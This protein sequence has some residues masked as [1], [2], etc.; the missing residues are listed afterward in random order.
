[1]GNR[2]ARKNGKYYDLK[3]SNKSFLQ[4]AKD[5]QTLGIKNWYFML[6]IYDYS[7]IEVDPF[8]VDKNGNT[9]L[10]KDQI[11]RI[12]LECARN[13]W[14]FLREISRIPDQG[15]TSIPY[16][17]NRGNI[18]QAWCIWK[19]LDSWLCLTRQ[20]GKTQ[21]ALAFQVWMYLFGTTNSQFIFINKDGDNAK[22]NLHRMTDQIDLLPEYM[23]CESYLDDDGRRVKGKKNATMITNPINNNS[24]ITKSKATS[25]DAALSIARGL[26]APILHFDEPEFT[27]HIKTIVSNSVSTYETAAAN[28]KR[29]HAMYARI[30]TCTPG[31]LDTKMGQEAQELLDKTAKWT[32]RLYDKTPE[33]IEEYLEKQGKDCNKILYIEYS[34]TQIGKTEKWLAEISA[35]IQDPLTVRR[36]ILLQRLHGSSLSPFNQED[37]EY[38]V[39]TQQKPIDELWLLDYYRFDIYKPLD[40]KIPYI[41]GVDCATGTNSDNN[42]ITVLNPYTLEP[43]AEFECSYIG[44][45]MYEKLIMELVKVI[46]RAILCIERNSMGDGIIDHLLHSPVS[47]RL[48]FD[49]ARDLVDENMKNNETIESML[50]KQNQKKRY[51]G[52]YTSSHTREDMMSILA[53]HVNEYKEKFITNN[54]IRDLSRLIRKSNGKIEAGPG[55]H[56]DSIMSYLI[57]LYVYYHGDNLSTFGFNKGALDSELNNSGL[58][59]P[60]EI[61]PDLVDKTIITD[62]QKQIQKEQVA[63]QEMDWNSMMKDAIMK[64]QKETFKMYQSNQIENTIFDHTEE[65]LVESYEEDGV[66]QMEF[67]SDMN[68]LGNSGYGGMNNNIPSLW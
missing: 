52:V 40:R 46:P 26:T 61:N 23:R 66:I 65:S 44:E 55:F 19:G 43:D 67:F 2:I 10:T 49:K 34:Y 7:L 3:T 14:Y 56:D 13:P 38:I 20:Q 63:K 42:S 22:T 53:R 35:K 29:N 28:A 21:S 54:I 27:E 59:R 64:S 4:V 18:A 58:K 11:S 36:E 32:E 57:A 25:Y 1:M 39:G 50:K 62:M 60:E 51:Y 16:K 45:T 37:I 31:D 8:A 68:Q 15:G 48:Y 30:F 47:N 17:A 5:L 24:V 41:V 12:M 6:E 9:T 33:Q